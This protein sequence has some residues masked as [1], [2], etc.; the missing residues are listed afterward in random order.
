MFIISNFNA[1]SQKTTIWIAMNAE[2]E[3]TTIAGRYNTIVRLLKHLG[4]NA[5]FESINSDEYQ[6]YF[7]ANSL[8]SDSTTFLKKALNS[9]A[10]SIGIK[11]FFTLSVRV[12]SHF[13]SFF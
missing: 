7:I 11:L 5:R 6:Y 3:D 1:L 4:E 12:N 10:F 13:P 8:L 9:C 2:T